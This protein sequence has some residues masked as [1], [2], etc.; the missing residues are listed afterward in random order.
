MTAINA[1][2][3]GLVYLTPNQ[4]LDFGNGGTVAFDIS[5]ERQSTRDWWDIWITPWADNLALPFDI[6]EVD[7][8]GP[9]LNAIHVSIETAES[10]PILTVYRNGQGT[11]FNH[12]WDTPSVRSGIAAGTN[13]A[14]A[15]QP[16]R[17]TI[18]GG[19]IKF[20][21]LASS[22][23]SAV[24]FFDFEASVNFS[25]GVVQFGHHSYNPSKDGSGVPATWHWDDFAINP[26]VPF[27]VIHADQRYIDSP[28]Q[29]LSFLTPAPANAFLR[30]SG[31]GIIEVSLD[32]GSYQPALRAKT[33][34]LS[35]GFHAEHMSN[36]WMPVPQGTRTLKLRFSADSWYNG[37][38]IAKDF[39]IWSTGGAPAPMPTPTR[40][41]TA[42]P[43]TAP[44]GTPPPTSTP[45]PTNVSVAGSVQLEG[46]ASAA[47]VRVV[48]SPGGASAVTG[49]GGTFTLTGL[50]A[51]TNYTITASLEGFVDARRTNLR[52][53]SGT[54]QLGTTLLRAG[55]IDGDKSVTVTDVSLVAGLYGMP[56]NGSPADL[57]ANGS[58]DVTDVSLAAGNYNLIG[59]TT[60]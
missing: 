14:A 25:R 31:I 35:D 50:Q 43:T 46:R 53:A 6:G 12:G 36:Y 21:R 13:E 48:A 2:G 60:W 28:T 19:R 49:P 16:F 55:D 15:R 52:V 26:S 22:T 45:A 37:P 5:T 47:G 54:A 1:G 7:L 32:G 44:G 41:P 58:I 39:A 51:N 9:P 42:T 10:A 29:T 59:P 33:A 23:G 56:A 30:F 27:T 38:Y 17:L 57:N 18:S 3:Y 24:E 11:T 8:Q 40:T 20:E 4:M 34:G